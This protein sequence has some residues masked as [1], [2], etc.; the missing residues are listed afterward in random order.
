LACVI[1]DIVFRQ[2]TTFNTYG[3]PAQGIFILEY[4]ELIK[5]EGKN[6]FVKKILMA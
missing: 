5:K 6:P 3:F 4:G 1:K 2:S